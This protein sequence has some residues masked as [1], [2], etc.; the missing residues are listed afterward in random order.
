MPTLATRA[1]SSAFRCV[2]SAAIAPSFFRPS[3]SLEP[4][5]DCH[6]LPITTGP[7]RATR[8]PRRGLRHPAEPLGRPRDVYSE[9]SLDREVAHHRLSFAIVDFVQNCLAF[10][11]VPSDSCDGRAERGKKENEYADF[12][13]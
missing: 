4:A 10:Q 13:D 1:A 11:A 9:I 5:I 12:H 3:F 6:L 7:A 2:R 8:H